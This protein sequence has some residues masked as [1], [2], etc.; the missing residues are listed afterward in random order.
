LGK[1]EALLKNELAPIQFFGKTGAAKPFLFSRL[2]RTGAP[3]KGAFAFLGLLFPRHEPN[4]FGGLAI[5][6]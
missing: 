4:H 5:K 2:C 1:A 6:R 3:S